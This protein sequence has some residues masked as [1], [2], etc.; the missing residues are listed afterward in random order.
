MGRNL[1]D[2]AV[3]NMCSRLMNSGY[4]DADIIKNQSLL[5]AAD[6][7]ITSTTGNYHDDDST[8]DED[9][10]DDEED[11][12]I[13]TS[14]GV[15]FE[16]CEDSDTDKETKQET[17]NETKSKTQGETKTNATYTSSSPTSSLDSTGW[18]NLDSEEQREIRRQDRL[19]NPSNPQ[20]TLPQTTRNT[21]YHQSS[22]TTEEEDQEFRNKVQNMISQKFG[23]DLLPADAEDLAFELQ[24]LLKSNNNEERPRMPPPPRQNGAS[25]KNNLKSRGQR[26]RGEDDDAMGARIRQDRVKVV[27]P[28]EQEEEAE[29]EEEQETELEQE[30]LMEKLANIG[31]CPANYQWN[32]GLYL[33]KSCGVCSKTVQNGWRCSGG[34][35]YVCFA[36]VNRD[37]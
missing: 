15:E 13:Q 29:E 26:I 30:A 5:V 17:K 25:K 36:C 7:N 19:S 11:N 27:A 22:E 3:E 2:R 16:I 21:A 1:V 23:A 4:S 9:G 37:G 14:Y 10:E 34:S 35:H 24:K 6:F 8:D 33:D 31:V 12:T 18:T 32:Q 20:N 28:K